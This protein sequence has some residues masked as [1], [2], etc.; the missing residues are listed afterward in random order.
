[1]FVWWG[2]LEVLIPLLAGEKCATYF[3]WFFQFLQFLQNVCNLFSRLSSC[4]W[5]SE[6]NAIP[7]TD[8]R[9]T[10][11]HA[12]CSNFAKQCNIKII[13]QFGHS[14]MTPEQ[15][16]NFLGMLNDVSIGISIF[17][18]SFWFPQ[19]DQLLPMAVLK[20]KI[21]KPMDQNKMTPSPGNKEDRWNSG[22][23]RW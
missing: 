10:Q 20:S 1:M 9:M 16:G 19:S 4:K 12:T 13:S 7:S 3:R 2:G 14:L 18:F 23:Q 11:A 17:A 8:W 15:D 5:L 21:W 6:K 22:K